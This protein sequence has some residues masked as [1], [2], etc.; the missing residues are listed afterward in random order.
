MTALMTDRAKARLVSQL[1]ALAAWAVALIFFFPIFW[2]FLTSFKTELEAISDPPLLFFRPTLENFFLIEERTD[3]SRYALNSVAVSFGSTALALAVAIPSAYAMA[4]FPGRFTKDLLL[5]MLSTKMLPAVGVL[6][7]IYLLSQRFG[8]LDTRTALI[9][10]HALINLPIVVWIL[11]TYFREIPREIL[12]AARMDGASVFS[13]I[14]EHR[15]ALEPGRDRLHRPPCNRPLMERSLLGHQ[16]DRRRRRDADRLGGFF[17]QPGGLVLGQALSRLHARLRADRGLRLAVPEAARPRPHLRSRQMTAASAA[18]A[19][20]GL[21]A[22][23]ASSPVPL[24]ASAQRLRPLPRLGARVRATDLGELEPNAGEEHGEEER[25]ESAAL[26]AGLAEGRLEQRS[27]D[28]AQ[29][30]ELRACVAW[31]CEPAPDV[32]FN[33]AAIFDAGSVLEA[34]LAQLD[35]LFAVNVRAFY[36]LLQAAARAMVQAG[37]KGAIVNVASQAGHRGEALVAHYCATKAAVIS[38]T[39]SAALALA[40]HGVR[41]NALSPGVIDTPMW[42]EVDAHFARLEG[43][44]KGEKKRLVGE[45][46]PLGAMGRPQD[47]ARAAV[48]LAGAQSSYM[49]AQTIGVDGGNVLR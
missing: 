3:W 46:V 36:A 21:E 17:L 31:I 41:V 35:R 48:F 43:R 9:I 16:P 47:V 5:W 11:F 25:E 32:L 40:P 39:Q 12:E 42:D 6:M 14:L 37:K 13:E 29:E 49:T 15:P 4:F 24:A 18:A 38:Y 1:L 10:V 44:P 22:R 23:P 19:L 34:D 8:L 20:A 30:P 26:A 2:L 7:P 27:F 28:L 33:N 45:E